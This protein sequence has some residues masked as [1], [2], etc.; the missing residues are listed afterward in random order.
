MAVAVT[1]T[2]LAQRARGGARG[3]PSPQIVDRNL[4]NLEQNGCPP[5][6]RPPDTAGYHNDALLCAYGILKQRTGTPPCDQ[7]TRTL[8]R[9]SEPRHT[10]KGEASLPT[11]R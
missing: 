10:L 2:A 9:R 5:Y 7:S 4:Q 6:P 3:A 11:R 8:R 1:Q